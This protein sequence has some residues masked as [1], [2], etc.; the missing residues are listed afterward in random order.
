MTPIVVSAW[1]LSSQSTLSGETEELIDVAVTSPFTDKHISDAIKTP[2]GAAT[3]Y[4][5]AKR[6]KYTPFIR[7]DTQK[8]TPV[9]VDSLGAWSNTAETFLSRVAEHYTKRFSNPTEARIH[10]YST[11]NTALLREIALNLSSASHPA[12]EA[13]RVVEVGAIGGVGDGG[14]A[15]GDGGTLTG[16]VVVG[17]C[18]RGVGGMS[19]GTGR[20]T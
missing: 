2:G 17:G 20:V 6:S 19:G 16:V 9:V 18:W 15:G 12:L 1:I 8:L 14:A 10:F 7:S 11:L 4:E 3:S 13:T 5:Q